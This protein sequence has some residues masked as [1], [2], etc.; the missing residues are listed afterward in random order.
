M[1]KLTFTEHP[2]VVLATNTFVNVPIVLQYEN[3]PLIQIVQQ[4]TAGYTIQIPIY[5]SDGTYLAK[6]IGSRIFPTA[7]G[8]KAGITL[9]HPDR[10][11]VCKQDGRTLF[12]IR[13]S[14]AAA[15]QT[16]AELYAPDGYFIKCADSPVPQLIDTSGN[17][18]R[19][20]GIT[21]SGNTFQGCR[22]GIW[23]KR[24]SLSL[25]CG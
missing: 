13:R 1:D 18:L 14:E 3:T 19:I 2:A 10:M 4:E 5:H 24:G 6:V 9:E 16:Q 25:G 23:V 11:T 22:I 17:A 8:K 7:D 21:M 20:G 15:L 12:E